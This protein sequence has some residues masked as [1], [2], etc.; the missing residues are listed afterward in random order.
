MQYV[1]F[2]YERNPGEWR[3]EAIDE[4]GSCYTI[5]FVGPF[6]EELARE[7]VKWKNRK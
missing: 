5:I 1:A 7:Y 4:E 3:V 6:A 2:E